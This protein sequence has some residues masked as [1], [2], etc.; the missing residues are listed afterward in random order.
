MP[1]LN[2]KIKVLIADDHSVF[3]EGLK[4]ILTPMKQIQ[5]VG[6]AVNG[7]E[8]ISAAIR[9]VPDV[10]LVDISMP[11]MDGITATKELRRRVPRCK[12]IALTVFEQENRICEMLNAGAC[13]YLS[14]TVDRLDIKHAIMTVYEDRS[15]F[16][17]G[18]PEQFTQKYALGE[19]D[20]PVFFT[21]REK[22]IIRL[23][24]NE[25][26][27]QEIAATL[28]LSKRTVEGHRTR[29]MHKMGVKSMSG[30]IRY[31]FDKGLNGLI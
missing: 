24:C 8:L 12:I 7:L 6:E 18:I 15:F 3:R 10:V 2:K 19:I 16:S 17:K 25:K 29:I 30:L 9:L 23:I 13:G 1:L 26:K 5:L 22:E 27:N 14:K 11:V 4:K 21:K 20:P 28:F 31:A